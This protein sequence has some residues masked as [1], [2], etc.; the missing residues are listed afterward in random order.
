MVVL[1]LCSMSM[2]T[3]ESP[4]VSHDKSPFA[5][6]KCQLCLSGEEE[7]NQHLWVC[8]AFAL[9]RQVLKESADAILMKYNVPFAKKKAVTQETK[10]CHSLVNKAAKAVTASESRFLSHDRLLRLAHGFTAHKHKNVISTASF[11][12]GIRSI[13]PTCICLQDRMHKW[14]PAKRFSLTAEACRCL[15]SHSLAVGRG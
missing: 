9:Q 8:P 14:R 1:H 10:T 13:L 12:P 2:A 4:C 7:T 15:Y 5:R 6:R 3:D 11:L